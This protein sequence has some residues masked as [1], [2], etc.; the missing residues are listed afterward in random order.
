MIDRVSRKK[1]SRVMA[2]IRSKD[3]GP[4]RAVRSALHKIGYRFQL[5]RTDLPGTPDLVLP[6]YRAVIFVHG[7]FWHQHSKC[8]LAYVPAS[9]TSYW[10]PKLQRNVER[11]GHQQEKL[12]ALGWKVLVVWECEVAGI[13]T[14]TRRLHR[15]LERRYGSIF[16][17]WY[18]PRNRSPSK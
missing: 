3:T 14:V 13:E 1:R 11:F 8:K 17:P 12:G 15:T 7:C 16:G 4:E 6:K 18:G 5:H 9:N 10:L 2:A